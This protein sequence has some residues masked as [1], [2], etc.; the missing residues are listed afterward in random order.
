MSWPMSLMHLNIITLL[1][2]L[3]YTC[4]GVEE[5]Q[6]VVAEK[7]GRSWQNSFCVDTDEPVQP[8]FKLRNFK[9]L[10]SSLRVIE[11]SNDKQKLWSD[12]A[13]AQAGL[14]LCW[15]HIPQCWKSCSSLMQPV[16]LWPQPTRSYPK[17]RACRR[18]SR[19]LA[20]LQA[21]HH[22]GFGQSLAWIPLLFGAPTASSHHKTWQ[23]IALLPV[24]V[25]QTSGP[26]VIKLFS[27][28]TQLNVNFIILINVKMPTIVGI[29][30]FI[31][32]INTKSESL[33]ARNVDTFH[34]FCCYEQLK[35]H[36]QLSW[37]LKKGYITSGPGPDFTKRN[38]G[39]LSE[40]QTFC[41][42]D[43]YPT[44]QLCAKVIS[45]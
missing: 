16:R 11:Y 18:G 40:I 9:C 27:C 41:R 23:K 12:C 10:V 21:Y 6:T 26:E 42:A 35:F 4:P 30:T 8:P 7:W 14:S 17:Q 13:Y 15:S 1:T 39:T 33:K 44:S 36:A 22:S 29:L 5:Q 20:Q 25:R 19:I 2:H 32:M 45:K 38:S 31:S 34:H 28:S 37:A 24:L 3:V 43:L